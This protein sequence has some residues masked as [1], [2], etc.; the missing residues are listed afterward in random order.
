MET[1]I[2]EKYFFF[3]L[4]TA[5]FIFT[6]LIFRP[7]W[8]VLVLGASFSIVLYPVFEW[9]TKMRLPNYLASFF[10]IILFTLVLCGPILGIGALVFK[11]TKNIYSSVIER[12]NTY[13]IMDSINTSVN[14][15]LPEGITFDM[16]QKAAD[17][18]SFLSNNVANIF[19]STVSAFFSFILMLLIIFFFLKDG[20]KWK[21]AIIILSPLSDK[22]DEKII[23][24]LK[25]A[26]NSVMMGNLFIALIQG[27][28]MGLGLWIFNVPNP[29]VWGLVAAVASFIPTIGTSLISIPAMI[30]LFSS[31]HTSSAIGLLVWAGVVVGLVDNFLSPIIIGEKINVPP[32]LILFSVLGGMSLLGPVGALLGPLT[33]SFLYTLIAIYRNEFKQNAQ[34]IP[35]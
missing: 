29:A 21:R 3:G 33:I 10:A 34:N 19:T 11:Q 27:L 13:P 17:F 26:V 35:A 14:N 7:F 30:F 9:F 6:F 22:N 18:I 25:I 8:V 1:K 16:N 31:G 15:I 12:Q 5:T 28:L 2:I 32:L 20:A 24:R 4:L 23:E